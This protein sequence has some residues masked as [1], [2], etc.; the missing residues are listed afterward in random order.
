[1][2]AIS[3]ATKDQVIIYFMACIFRYGKIRFKHLL[4]NS[5]EDSLE[6]NDLNL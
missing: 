6:S 2:I 5:S 4:S 3:L 1:M